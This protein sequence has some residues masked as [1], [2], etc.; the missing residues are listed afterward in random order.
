MIAVN[1][2]AAESGAGLS[3]SAFLEAR[4]YD[5]RR[6]AVGLNDVVVP[7]AAYGEVI[8]RDGDRVDVVNFVSGG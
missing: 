5:L 6:V 7:K 8:L 2:E 3:I 1:G 4:G